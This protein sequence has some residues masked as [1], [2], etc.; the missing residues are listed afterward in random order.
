MKTF[1]NS[2]FLPAGL[3]GSNGPQWV[4]ER[5]FA[6][7]NLRNLGMGKSNLE[8]AINQEAQVCSKFIYYDQNNFNILVLAF[9]AS[10]EMGK[11]RQ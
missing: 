2:E 9:T 7:R 1:K 5:R 8:I 6:L 11:R 10:T 3:L 4:H